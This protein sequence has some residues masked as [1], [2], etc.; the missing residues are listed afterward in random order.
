MKNLYLQKYLQKNNDCINEKSKEVISTPD[1][2]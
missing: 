2:M 1:T